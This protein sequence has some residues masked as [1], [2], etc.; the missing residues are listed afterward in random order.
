MFKPIPLTKPRVM[1]PPNIYTPKERTPTGKVLFGGTLFSIDNW[2]LPIFISS[3]D[4]E[5]PTKLIT[6]FNIYILEAEGLDPKNNGLTIRIS[7]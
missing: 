7:F 2:P 5:F 6:M 4:W 1:N 3:K